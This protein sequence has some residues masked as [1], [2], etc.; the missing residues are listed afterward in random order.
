MAEYTEEEMNEMAELERESMYGAMS[1]QDN[2]P[3]VE[4]SFTIFQTTYLG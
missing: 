4:E 2:R 1:H 3:S